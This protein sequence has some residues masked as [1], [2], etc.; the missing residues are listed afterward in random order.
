MADTGTPTRT[1]ECSLCCGTMRI[2]T[3]EEIVRI[4]GID[5]YVKRVV[6][7]WECPD[8]SCEEEIDDEG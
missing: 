4:P 6:R 8:C 5:Q 7:E 1:R 2:R 3:R